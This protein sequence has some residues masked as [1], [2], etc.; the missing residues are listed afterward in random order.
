[1]QAWD[2]VVAEQSA[3]LFLVTRGAQAVAERPETIALAQSP[4][5][6]LGR[7]V[8]GEYP[9]LRCTL[10]DLDPAA[11]DGGLAA[12]FAE[13]HAEDDEDEVAWRGPQRYGHRYLPA[14]GRPDGAE[15][16]TGVPYRLALR[17]A[18]TLDGLALQTIRRRTPGPGEVEIEVVAAG[19]NF[20]DVM[21]A[22][23]LY[24]GL[25]DGPI[26]LGAECSGR[27]TA[28]GLG[29]DSLRVGD[30]VLAVAGFAFGSHVI[31]K[32][33]L[34][35][36][37]P[38][39]LS[40]EEAATLPIAFLTAAYALEHLG[41]IAPGERVLIHSATG[42]VGLA[43]IQIA[44][45]A[46]AEIFATA[47]TPEKREYLRDLGIDLVMDSRSLAFVDEVR[48]RTGGRGVDLILNSLPGEAI[49][50]GMAALAD[51][52]R[53]LEIGKRD[54]DQNARLGLRP[55]RNNLSFFAIDLD[56]VTR[57][58]PAL[59]GGLLQDI[60]RAVRD[61]ELTPSPHRAW[62][63]T[64][65]VDA[66]RFMQHSKHIGKV[67]VSLQELTV[68]AIP[69]EDEPVTFAAD[70]TYL[71]TG[72]LGGFGREVARWMAGRGAGNLVLVGRRNADSAEAQQAVADVEQL[73]ARVL[74]RAADVSR[75]DDLVAVLAEIDR[76]LP[77]LRGVIHAAMVL[78]DAL[79]INLDRELLNRVLAP[80][81]T[82]AWNLHAQ[83]AARPLDFFVLFSSLS[84]VFGHAG[85]GNYA[86]ANAF[87]DALAWHRRALGLPALAVNWGYLGEVGYLA[88][89]GELG[90]RLE[91]QGVL[92]FTV[93]EALALLEKA[94]LREHTQVGVMR[95]EWSRWRGLGVSGRV[96]PRFAH[97]CRPDE[98]T[99]RQVAGGQRT[100][101]DAIRA[102]TAED[103][104][105]LLEGLLRDKVARVLGT[106]SDRLDGDRPLLQ[107]GLDSLMAVE[108][109]NWIEA[110]LRVRLP[111]VELMRSPSLVRLAERLAAQFEVEE[112]VATSPTVANG[113]TNGQVTIN[114][115]LEAAPTELLARVG[116]LSGEQVDAL[117]AALLAEA[118][119]AARR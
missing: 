11:E 2:Q 37:K 13:I 87:L 113:H 6:G 56:R 27:V 92:S 32:A 60:V 94:M 105:G 119:Q 111:I 75:A 24:P 58:R 96:S 29:V 78:E 83:T 45:R 39:R 91:R 54:I 23:G 22:L 71:I 19:L 89:R 101:G 10:V 69:S 18:G 59:L 103:R 52:G 20:S 8:A 93:D 116:D 72:G 4:A 81:V 90:E 30:E 55:F 84:S 67:V 44:R 38:D 51:Y 114:T 62:P 65:A 82:G 17:H 16:H 68:A 104:P 85:Q 117:L 73:G 1:V 98:T 109:G 107:L 5:I 12:L 9:R 64:E 25:P 110:E 79:L 40:F 35:A 21:K 42:G 86:A 70:G 41:R 33:E 88:R 34:V 36:R 100:G 43:A 74:V 106:A 7:V 118:G 47:G 49:P 28:V 108:L 26:A 48:S 97:L 66:F 77:P 14:P 102:A 112:S 15:G 57:E 76:D 31:T 53:F 95:M 50:A 115:V 80:K 99:N 63:I 3:P 61:E 46:G